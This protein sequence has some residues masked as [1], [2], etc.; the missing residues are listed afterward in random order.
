MAINAPELTLTAPKSQNKKSV[1][2]NE[3]DEPTG[4]P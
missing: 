3:L 2:D 1:L 4:Q